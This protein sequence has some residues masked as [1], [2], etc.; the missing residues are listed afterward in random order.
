MKKSL[1]L[2]CTILIIGCSSLQIT[3]EGSHQYTAYIA[4]K[5]TG[6]AIKTFELKGFYGKGLRIDLG[7]AWDNLIERNKEY[8]IVSGKEIVEFYNEVLFIIAKY[9]GDKYGL[10]ADLSML[11]IT[12][13]AKF[14]E[15]GTMLK[16]N[17]IPFLILTRFEFGFKLGVNTAENL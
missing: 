12:F 4:G 17:D 8:E 11:M 7:K 6:I 3:D 16:I 5:G 13:S 2:I 1:I 14:S 9:K 10:I 15:K